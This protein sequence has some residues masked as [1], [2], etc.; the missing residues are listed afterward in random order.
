MKEW[1]RTWQLLEGL[2]IR[3]LGFGFRRNGKEMETSIGFWAVEGVAKVNGNQYNGL[4]RDYYND[5]IL[6]S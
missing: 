4:S 5:P 6:H 2:G 1:K 3:V